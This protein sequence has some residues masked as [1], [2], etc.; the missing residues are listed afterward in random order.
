MTVFM[1][2]RDWP[3]DH[4]NIYQATVCLSTWSWYVTVKLVYANL[5]LNYSRIGHFIKFFFCLFLISANAL[6]TLI[7]CLSF[8][9]FCGF[10]DPKAA[11]FTCG[12][13]DFLSTF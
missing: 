1:I 10:Y 12:T 2:V 13:K 6:P 4:S 9:Y 11:H 8:S 5:G 7:L 3:R